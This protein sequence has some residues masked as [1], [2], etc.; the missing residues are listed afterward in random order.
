MGGFLAD[1]LNQSATDP[2]V[3]LP[4]LQGKNMPARITSLRI[5]D[6]TIELDVLPMDAEQREQLLHQIRQ[7]R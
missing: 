1:V 3:F 5:V 7:P 2:V 4:L 6:H